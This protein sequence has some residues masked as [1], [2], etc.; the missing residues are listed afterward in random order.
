MMREKTRKTL[1]WYESRAGVWLRPEWKL[2]DA[3][4]LIHPKRAGEALDR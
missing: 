4:A 2:T 1:T 3:E